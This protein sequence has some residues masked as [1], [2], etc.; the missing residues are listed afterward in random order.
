MRME[1]I[2]PFIN[3]ADA[4][5]AESLQGPTKIV[6]LEMDEEAYRRKGVA[7]LIAIKGDIEGRVILD[8]SPEVAMKVATILAGTEMEAS[9]QVVRETVCEMANMVIGNSVTLLNDQGFHFKVFPP[10][11]HMD[12]TGLAGSADT[13]ALVICIETPCGNIYLNIAMHYLHRRRQERN[14]VPALD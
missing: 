2:Q 5:F 10:E 14:A 4:V 1:L 9:D 12:E 7:A 6:D 8:L 13:E 11:I 3:A